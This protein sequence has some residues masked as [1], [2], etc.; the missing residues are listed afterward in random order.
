MNKL[1][2]LTF[3][4]L[5]GCSTFQDPTA[6]K[7]EVAECKK[8]AH[9]DAHDNTSWGEVLLFGAPIAHRLK[10]RES[11]S[12]CMAARGYRTTAGE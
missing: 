2:I 9:A 11:F 6:S 8:L 10:A 12:Q 7:G 3:A 5:T 4:A 1:L